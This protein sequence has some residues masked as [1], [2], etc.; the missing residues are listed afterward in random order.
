MFSRDPRSLVERAVGACVLLLIGAFALR[1]A[2]QV[3]SSVWVAL[4]II[5]L[6]AGG[7]VAVTVWL[8]RRNNGW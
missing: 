7:A 3:I 1:W 2:V 4:L 5:F 8:R 6:V